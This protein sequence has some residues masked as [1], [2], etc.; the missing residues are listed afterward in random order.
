MTRLC[1]LFVAS[2]VAAPLLASAAVPGTI[3][4]SARIADNGRPVSG[5]Q[6]FTFKLWTVATGGTAGTDDVWTEGP[7]SITVNDGVVATALGDVANGGIALP[8][9]TGVDLFLEVTMGSTVF[10]RVKLQTVPYA[11]LAE[12][13]VRLGAKSSGTA[14]NV[15]L[16]T[17]FTQVQVASMSVTF[18]SAGFAFILFEAEP[19]GCGSTNG[20]F[21]VTVDGTQQRSGWYESGSTSYPHPI[22]KTFVMSVAAGTHTIAGN[23][24]AGVACSVWW[25]EISVLFVP[26]SL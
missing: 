21:N 9:F 5:A 26:N 6:S 11:M 19:F 2:L 10:P 4:F 24:S 20:N 3:N 8:S 1:K 15:S 23:I 14:G 7:R 17:P 25:P 18:P 12:S 16:P 22:T 13:V